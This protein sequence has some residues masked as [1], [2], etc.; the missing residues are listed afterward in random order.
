MVSLSSIAI[1]WTHPHS[2]SSCQ[3]TQNIHNHH[4]HQ[5][6]HHQHHHQHH[7]HPNHH[8]HIQN[9]KFIYNYYWLSSTHINP[10]YPSPSPK[11]HRLRSSNWPR[12]VFPKLR[13]GFLLPPQL[14]QLAG[15]LHPRWL[16]ACVS[17]CRVSWLLNGQKRQ[18]PKMAGLFQ[19]LRLSFSC[20]VCISFQMEGTIK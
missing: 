3:T 19:F 7:H 4:Q 11:R 14:K 17:L 1:N 10:S 2:N 18:Y 20:F 8:H 13:Q 12:L 6:Q 15:T 16:V 9:H 5:H